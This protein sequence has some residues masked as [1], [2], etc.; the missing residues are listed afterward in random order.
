MTDFLGSLVA[1]STGLRGELEP[2]PLTRFDPVVT[3]LTP[4]VDGHEDELVETDTVHV[5]PP[6]ARPQPDIGRG[7]KSEPQH[8]E[9][10][11]A[12]VDVP[13]T[14]ATPPAGARPRA[15]AP[16]GRPRTGA[17]DA[18]TPSAVSRARDDRPPPVAARAV[19]RPPAPQP[20]AR[21]E[22]PRVVTTSPPPRSEPVGAP[23]G[24]ED[25]ADVRPSPRR[26]AAAEDPGDAVDRATPADPVP[27]PPQG[28][29][30]PAT[31]DRSLGRVANS[32]S[33]PARRSFGAEQQVPAGL[34]RPEEWVPD[35]T[36][37]GWLRPP[38]APA[39]A[40]E[41]PPP[42]PDRVATRGEPVI[43][44]TIGRVEV[45]SQAG[46]VV[47]RP[48]PATH[49]GVLPLAE[50]LARRTTRDR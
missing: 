20:P 40:P 10:D 36:P 21:E 31:G 1:R 4:S 5:P 29:A 25:E 50:Y 44:V 45:R 39:A 46:T 13:V 26:L 37:P 35:A 9:H 48:R 38:P 6:T 17:A 15:A 33:G 14:T 2:R 7:Q 22:L 41:P 16:V 3:P 11:H 30:G 47:S 18:S 8:V 23:E 49:P 19:R 34:A 28:A 24:A 12:A 42:G 32:A 43:E 27:G